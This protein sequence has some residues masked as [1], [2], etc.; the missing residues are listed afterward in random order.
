MDRTAQR[1][2]MRALRKAYVAGQTAE[3]LAQDHAALA[4][5]TLPQLADFWIIGSYMAVGSELDPAPLEAILRLRGQRI[6]LPIVTD[7]QSPLH[8][9]FHDVD[10]VLTTGPIGKIP[11]P[12][13]SAQMA[14]PEALLVP[15][16]AADPRGVRLGQGAG[17]YDRTIAARRPM[18][19]LGLAYDCQIV[20]HIVEAP[21]D[22]RLDAIV[23]PTRLIICPR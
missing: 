16:L 11:Q 7:A 23:T 22:V 10:D 18:F 3:A 15:L 1:A 19:T 5:L 21:W 4:A 13:S 8:F 2:H 12:I 9:A 20:D 17:H 6:A 14:E